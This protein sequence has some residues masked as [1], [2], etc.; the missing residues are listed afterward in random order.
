MFSKGVEAVISHLP[1]RFRILKLN[2][3]PINHPREV[4]SCRIIRILIEARRRI[5]LE[6]IGSLRAFLGSYERSN[7]ISGIDRDDDRIRI[8]FSCRSEALQPNRIFSDLL[9]IEANIRLI[10]CVERRA[11]RSNLCYLPL[12]VQDRSLK[13]GTDSEFKLFVHESICLVRRNRGDRIL[14]LKTQRLGD[15]IPLV[16]P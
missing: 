14:H 16:R 5:Q 1:I 7:G 3:L 15:G 8:L 10:R 6:D 13:S 11:A 9:E 4:E 2:R 12:I